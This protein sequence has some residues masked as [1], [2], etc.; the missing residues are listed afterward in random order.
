VLLGWEKADETRADLLSAEEWIRSRILGLRIFPD[1]EGKMNLSLEKYLEE[2]GGKSGGIL[3]VSQFTLGATLESGFRPSFT[4]SMSPD[5]ARKR[6]EDFCKT[7]HC[8]SGGLH[9]SGEFGADMD[10]SFC[11]W[12]P[13]TIPLT[14]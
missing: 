9:I 14:R 5:I 7:L 13:V 12:G 10:L 4:N 11:N 8:N 3:W 6:F 1:R 2:S